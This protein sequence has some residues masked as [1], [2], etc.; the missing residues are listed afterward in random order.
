MDIFN[1]ANGRR[2][3]SGIEREMK[4]RVIGF[5]TAKDLKENVKGMFNYMLAHFAGHMMEHCY[6]NSK[7][8]YQAPEIVKDYEVLELIEQECTMITDF[9]DERY[10]F[11]SRAEVESRVFFSSEQTPARKFESETKKLAMSPHIMEAKKEEREN[12]EIVVMAQCQDK[13]TDNAVATENSRSPVKI[14]KEPLLESH[15]EIPAVLGEIDDSVI[16]SESEEEVPALKINRS[17][18]QNPVKPTVSKKPRMSFTEGKEER[19]MYEN[20]SCEYKSVCD[21]RNVT[22][23]VNASRYLKQQMPKYDEGKERVSSNALLEDEYVS[24]SNGLSE[25]ITTSRHKPKVKEMSITELQRL[26]TQAGSISETKNPKR[27]DFLLQEMRRILEEKLAT[28]QYSPIYENKYRRAASTTQKILVVDPAKKFS[29]YGQMRRPSNDSIKEENTLHLS[30]SGTTDKDVTENNPVE[31]FDK[32]PKKFVSPEA[33]S[34]KYGLVTKDT[35]SLGGDV[36][37]LKESSMVVVEK[38]DYEDNIVTCSYKDL[39][40]IFPLDA[41]RIGNT[42]SD[43]I[44]FCTQLHSYCSKCIVL[45]KFIRQYG[46]IKGGKCVRGEDNPN[47]VLRV[48]IRKRQYTSP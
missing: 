37:E 41:I 2:R 17:T 15:E 5:K 33:Q 11:L 13:N 21:A 20:T 42:V 3:H 36:F 35:A 4:N 31:K 16:Q 9:K 23:A 32:S 19:K 7:P 26:R 27:E 39:R 22:K 46:I 43:S 29:S 44:Q 8:F 12:G 10:S 14:E 1:K 18:V 30:I 25:D 24:R 40:G 6:P 47:I 38:V 34:R 28:P 45:I 48:Q